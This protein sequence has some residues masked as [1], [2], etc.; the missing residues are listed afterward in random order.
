MTYSISN[1]QK[2]IKEKDMD[3]RISN[4][5]SV[6]GVLRESANVYR[7]NFVLLLG[8]S[9]LSSLIGLFTSG[10]IKLEGLPLMGFFRLIG[11]LIMIV[12][13]YYGI[14]LGI[15]IQ[16][17]IRDIYIGKTTSVSSSYKEA[18]KYIW[19]VLSASLKLMLMLVIPFIAVRSG[20]DTISS[21]IIKIPLILIG[22]ISF[23]YLGV[24]NVFGPT[25]RVLKPDTKKYF[26]YSREIVKNNFLSVFVLISI[27]WILVIFNFLFQSLMNTSTLTGILSIIIENIPMIL[28]IIYRPFQAAIL[29]IAFLEL[30]RET[31]NK[32]TLE[33]I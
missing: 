2:R 29:I 4:R 25:I 12:G 14:K 9:L 28:G 22:S 23:V 19:K 20:M 16:I 13:M 1:G 15:A 33:Y 5:L 10:V 27:S 6:V 31:T 18:D 7:N 24:R 32:E 3:A 11:M 30:E 21:L 8:L 26:K 17:A